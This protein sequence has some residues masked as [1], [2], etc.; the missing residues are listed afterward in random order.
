MGPL[1]QSV[2]SSGT[3]LPPRLCLTVVLAIA[4]E[5]S[6]DYELA[7]SLASGDAAPS[8]I[9]DPDMPFADRPLEDPA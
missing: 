6:P 8:C 3:L 2:P 9:Q 7:S 5:S 1:Q 4:P